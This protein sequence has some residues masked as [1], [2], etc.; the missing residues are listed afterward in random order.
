M[1]SE[2]RWYAVHTQPQRETLVDRR[3][4]AQRFDTFY[5]FARVR[6]RIKLP[7]REQ[8]RVVWVNRPRYARYLFVRCR[9]E[10]IW[11]INSTDGVSTVVYFDDKPASIPDETMTA[12]IEL[13]DGEKVRDET[14]RPPRERL[15]KGDVVRFKENSPFY[16]LMSQV[17]LDTGKTIR[18]VSQMFGVDREVEVAPNTVAKIA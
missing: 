5:P 7:N 14:K 13:C 8:Y 12:L 9:P 6:K 4:R 15:K 17:A 1:M 16:G 3:L 18:V 10:L 2:P 11:A